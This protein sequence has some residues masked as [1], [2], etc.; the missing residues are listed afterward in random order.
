VVKGSTGMGGDPPLGAII[1]PS[2]GV[3]LWNKRYRKWWTVFSR[4]I[5]L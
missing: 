3:Q 1:H 4:P 5:I 2:I